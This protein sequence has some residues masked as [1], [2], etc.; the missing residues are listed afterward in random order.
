MVLELCWTGWAAGA[1]V[2][3]VPF[4]AS[5]CVIMPSGD[6]KTTV[7]VLDEAAF[8]SLMLWTGST[9]SALAT[10]KCAPATRRAGIRLA[11]QVLATNW[12]LD[13]L[14]LVP[15]MVG[16]GSHDEHVPDWHS[17]DELSWA[18]WSAMVP[19]WFRTIGVNYIAFVA[20]C[21]VA[22]HSAEAAVA[23]QEKGGKAG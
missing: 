6:G 10:M 22:G 4:L 12:L 9:A 1:F 13:L 14:V 20:M 19:Y 8:R 17:R 5:C 3:L 18:S 23:Q 2:W 7:R 21:V 11:V 15:L 16:D